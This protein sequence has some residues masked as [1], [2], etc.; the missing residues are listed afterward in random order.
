MDIVCMRNR[1]RSR[2]VGL[3]VYKSHLTTIRIMSSGGS[4]GGSQGATDP[5]FWLDQVLTSTDDRL[6]GALLPGWRTK[7]TASVAHLSMP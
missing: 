3:Y 2:L 7:I 6:N 1:G 5:P 4:R